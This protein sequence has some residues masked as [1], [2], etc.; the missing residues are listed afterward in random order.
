[1]IIIHAWHKRAYYKVVPFKCLVDRGWL[2]HP[3]GDRF[4][5]VYGECKGI[6]A[7]IPADHIN[8]MMEVMD[9]VHNPLLFCHNKKITLFINCLQVLRLPDVP[10][11]IGGIFHQLAVIAH[12][13]FRITDRAKRFYNKKPVV[14]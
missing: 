4:E 3:P 1:M 2:M 13:S 7:P 14:L 5:I 11:T 10:F 6:T 9:P 12:I 8:G